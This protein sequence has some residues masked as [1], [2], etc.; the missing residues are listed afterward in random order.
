MKKGDFRS[1]VF[2]ALLCASA[3][4]LHAFQWPVDEKVLTA[5]F[6]ESRWDHY[7]SGIDLAGGA[8]E[9]RPVAD[10]EVIFS[11]DGGRSGRIL[12]S[13]LGAFIV[14]EHEQGIRSLYAHLE[15]AIGA[16]I[17][18]RVGVDD[19]IGKIGE[20]GASLGKHLHLEIIDSELGSYVNP[21]VV[22]PTLSDRIRPDIRRVMIV[23]TSPPASGTVTLKPGQAIGPGEYRL[24][25]ELYD[26]SEFVAYFC[27]MAPYQVTGFF[28]GS[29]VFDIRFDTI[30]ERDGAL[31]LG[32]S[33]EGRTFDALYAEDWIIDAG[34]APF[35]R[36][37]IQIEIVA[38]DIAGNE[39]ILRIPVTVE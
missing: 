17:P 8:Q 37:E 34:I 28:N 20:S 16:T 2:I 33:G 30:S 24:L 11:F 29:E 19:V 23:P 7:H 14:I 3:T 1:L 31:V 4:S 15:P 5:T 9:V 10:G 18:V 22:L 27:P 26:R 35:R 32:R 38:R 36:G 6:G 39:S 12:P 25:I 13:G 21:L